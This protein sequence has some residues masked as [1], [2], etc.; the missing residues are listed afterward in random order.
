MSAPFSAKRGRGLAIGRRR[1]PVFDRLWPDGWGVARASLCEKFALMPVRPS[2]E[3]GVALP[4]PIRHAPH[5]TF[6]GRAGEG[7]A[8]P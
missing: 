2:T 5:D 8:N 1:T 6:P 7:R 3:S 4:H